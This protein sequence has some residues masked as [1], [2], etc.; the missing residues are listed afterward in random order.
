MKAKRHQHGAAAAIAADNPWHVQ[1]ERA[2][3]AGG[4]FQLKKFH[5]DIKRALINRRA[6]CCCKIS[7]KCVAVAR[8]DVVWRRALQLHG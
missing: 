2:R 1:A 3:R 4:A 5:N 6:A 8:C 7:S